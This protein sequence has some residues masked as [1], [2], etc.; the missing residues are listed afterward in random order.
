MQLVGPWYRSATLDHQPTHG[1]AEGEG[2][3]WSADRTEAWRLEGGERR[4][5][6]SLEEASQLASRLTAPGYA[7]AGGPR[8][9]ALPTKPSLSRRLEQ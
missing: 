4:A 3:A 2:V 5:P 6:L 1:G 9:P 8:P 7:P